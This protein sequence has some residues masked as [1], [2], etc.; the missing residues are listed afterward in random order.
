MA[1][2]SR[3]RALVNDAPPTPPAKTIKAPKPQLAPVDTEKIRDVSLEV[4][5]ARLGPKDAAAM[6]ENDGIEKMR[7]RAGI[8]D[9]LTMAYHAAF[10][11]E[12]PRLTIS[13][14]GE[15]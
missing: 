11:I 2:A 13:L 8:Y 14:L 9:P 4:Y 15:G 3:L 10:G 1:K 7:K 6:L 5:K 12:V